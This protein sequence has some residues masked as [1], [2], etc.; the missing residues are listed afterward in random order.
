MWYMQVVKGDHYK[1]LSKHN[2]I[3]QRTIKATRG[4][5]FDRNENILIDNYPYFNLVMIPENVDDIDS[6]LKNLSALIEIDENIL[7]EKIH[8]ARNR[9]SFKPVTLMENLS[10][11]ELSK[12]EANKLKIPGIEI[13]VESIRYYPYK[14]LASHIIGYLSEINSEKLKLKE[15]KDYK[16]GDLIG[17]FGIER[18]YEELLK[19]ED[20]LKEVEVDAFGRGLATLGI[21]KAKPV[22]TLFLTLD[23]K[24]QIYV[25][26]VFN[27]KAGAAVVMEVNNGKVLAQYSKPNFDPSLFVK[28][29][30]SKDWKIL[31]EN[32]LYPLQNKVIMGQYSPGSVF[33]PVVAAAALEEGIINKNSSF[34]CGGSYRLGRSR[35]SCWKK[36]GHGKVDLVDA[37][38]QSCDVYFYSLGELLGVDKIAEYSYKFGLGEVTGIDLEYEKQG[39]IPTIE[40]KKRALNSDWFSG[41]TISISIGQ[42][43]TLV[44]PLQIT[45]VTAAIANGERVPIPQLLERVEGEDGKIIREYMPQIKKE[46]DISKETIAVLKEGMF[47]VINSSEGTARGSKPKTVTAAG[48]T[49]TVQVFSTKKIT[50][51]EE[52]GIPY[53]LIDHA[54]FTCYAPAEKPK[55]AVTILVEHGGHG[56]EAA[57]PIAKKIIDYYFG[58]IKGDDD[59]V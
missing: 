30:S 7:K 46:L 35:F 34:F 12:I 33:K 1:N 6:L 17:N 4:L 56:A 48:K 15:Y 37:I 53:E 9:P 31:S 54:W 24:L 2:R 14:T 8:E 10:R 36:S 18:T 26:E 16:P 39:L 22:N 27:D 19:G 52:E 51:S 23:S 3:R 5:I 28:G 58:V 59:N 32:P 40:W 29:I 43:Y 20:G 21:K 50:F 45:A 41:E 25:E 11:E 57:A 49:G 38:V 42:S 13:M 44:T 47:G 55:I